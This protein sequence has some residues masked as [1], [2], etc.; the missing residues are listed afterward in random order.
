[1][2]FGSPV[3]AAAINKVF[4]LGNCQSPFAPWSNNRFTESASPY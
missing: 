2:S 1:M 3:E 4:P